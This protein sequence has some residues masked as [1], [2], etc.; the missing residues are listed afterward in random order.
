[1]IESIDVVKSIL[2]HLS[3]KKPFS[4]IRLGDGE[5]IILYNTHS[6]YIGMWRHVSKRQW[7]YY[8]S[9]DAMKKIRAD[10]ENSIKN[11]T[12]L[13]VPTNYHNTINDWWKYIGQYLEL[14]NIN[15]DVCSIDI[16]TD[17]RNS[18]LLDSILCEYC[19][20]LHYISGHN[21]ENGFKLKYLNFSNVIGHQIPP[22][23]MYFPC[24]FTIP[25]YPNRF[26]DLINEIASE[27]REGQLWLVGGGILGKIYC[28]E[29][30]KAGG[31]AL[32]LGH[33]FD[34]WAGYHTR[35]REGK[36]ETLTYKL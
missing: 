16:H 36:I 21:L 20:V 3:E 31:I 25:H 2:E 30:R 8:V 33:I 29:I 35:G 10:L 12:L 6:E 15:I 32:D 4:L 9:E 28:E 7:G 5:G 17:L 22:E 19:G 34:G 26:F 14:N 27:K 23:Q 11:A 13:G 18:G 24:T 1:M